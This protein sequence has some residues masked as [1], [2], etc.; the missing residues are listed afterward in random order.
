MDEMEREGGNSLRIRV[1]IDVQ[2][3]L[4]RG[5]MIRIGSRGEEEW[6][7]MRFEKLPDYCYGCGRLGHLAKECDD[8]ESLN[9]NKPQYG[10]GLKMEFIPKGK[11]KN[12]KENERKE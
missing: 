4:R 6:I 11:S 5:T 1:K 9:S 8:S 12:K 7:E 3:P 10:I 2:K